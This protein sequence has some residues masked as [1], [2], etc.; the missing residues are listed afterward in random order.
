MTGLFIIVGVVAVVAA[1]MMLL[2]DNAVHSALFLIL[3]FAC[4][5]FFYLML[6]APFL[7]MVQIAVYAGAI[8]VLFLF[9]IMLLGAEQAESI[10]SVSA[11]LPGSR[12]YTIVAAALAL[13]L[14]VTVGFALTGDTIDDIEPTANP[15]VRVV[16]GAATVSRA[17]IELDG[18]VI[19]ED[20]VYGEVTRM[21][22]IAPGDHEVV[23]FDSE[24][25]EVIQ[26]GTLAIEAPET[27]NTVMTVLVYDTYETLINS[28]EATQ[29]LTAFEQDL[30][31]PTGDYARVTV[32][33]GL[34]QPISFH[35]TGVFGRTGDT[36]VYASDLAPGTAS[37]ALLL[38]E[39]RYRSLR[40]VRPADEEADDGAGEPLLTIPEHTFE[41]SSVVL[42]MVNAVP[43]TEFPTIRYSV[44]E[45]LATFGSPQAVGQRLFVEYLLPMQLVALVL[46]AALVGVIVIAQRQVEPSAARQSAARRPVRRRV[47]R[48][49]ASVITS[50]V[51]PDAPD[52][53]QLKSGDEP[54]GD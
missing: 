54:A 50:Q 53:T 37:D 26:S 12:R 33:N 15:V 32:F 20:V 19:A 41:T 31:P 52:G 13:V 21:L 7:A 30:N 14:L 6:D 1:V 40:V 24:T 28:G 9:V 45:T 16:H 35:D 46:L 22:E 2:S 23:V 4:V 39:G 44:T 43:N 11:G 17:D 18:I 38:D 27:P 36:F 48:P 34:G 49:L 3:N 51:A 8:M 47:S 25:G 10:V 5:A 29:A 42:M